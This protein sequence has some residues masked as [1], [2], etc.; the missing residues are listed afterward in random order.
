MQRS[1]ES[2]AGG[3]YDIA[4]I[5]GG[6][7][8]AAIAWDATLRG[9]RVALFEREDFGWATS[10][11]SAKI[12]H[13]GM[14][15]L[16]HADLKRLRESMRERNYLVQNAPHLVDSQPFI[17]PVYGH[18]VKGKEIFGLYLRIYDWLS[19]AKK[20]F[21]D[22]ARRIA[23]SGMIRPDE[24]RAI[25]PG[26]DANRLTGAGIWQEGQMHNTERLLLAYLRA[27]VERGLDIANYAEVTKV[28]HSDGKATGLSVRDRVTGTSFDVDAPV[29]INASGPWALETLNESGLTAADYGIYASKAFSLLTKQFTDGVAFTF[30]IKPMYS[31]K[32]AIVDKGSSMQFAIPWR[33]STMIASLHLASGTEKPE[34]IVITDDE[35]DAYIEMINEG[36]PQAELKRE[37]VRNVLWGIIP[38]EEQ[39]SA[40]P[41][42]HYK[43]VDHGAHNDLAGLV[44][45]VGV[46]YTTARDV[47]QKSVDLVGKY[48]N[49]SVGVSRS[50]STPLW[51]G[52]IDR[53]DEFV[54]NAV[55]KNS[56][57]L[58][59]SIVT[60]L[61]RSYGTG[62]TEITALIQSQPDLATCITGTE[63]TRAEIVY[64]I[65]DEMARTLAD[66]VLRRTDMGSL[67]HPGGQ[68]L[69]DTAALM[70][71][72]LDWD[73]DTIDEMVSEVEVFFEQRP[74][75]LGLAAA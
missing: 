6:I 17:M 64:A 34:D 73:N 14:R 62:L 1:L 58:P 15:Y 13:C 74:A 60:R 59:E 12:G 37:D 50:S 30:P 75:R 43:I 66:V 33:D 20:R 69:R 72:Y 39:G 46:K 35:I 36:Y 11:N 19:T 31:D 26:V 49:K 47:A 63:I 55:Q 8:G 57:H 41:L 21:A 68:A 28:R 23:N 56:D 2:M 24:V 32:K 38:A 53:L 65:R 3:V 29:V 67:E 18:G 27:G 44:T 52:D 7:N 40:A 25:M 48:M 22:P 16:Q 10:S 70:A 9:L 71:D 45:V 51:G 61:C 4:V 42:K 54:A 5:G